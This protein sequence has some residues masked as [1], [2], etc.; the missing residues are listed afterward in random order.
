MGGFSGVGLL[1]VVAVLESLDKTQAWIET[2]WNGLANLE[3][4]FLAPA[5]WQGQRICL[6]V[7]CSLVF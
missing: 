5:H 6:L 1:A 4:R 7:W 2:G 3:P